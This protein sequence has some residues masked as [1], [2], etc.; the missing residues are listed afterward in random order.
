MG[1][2]LQSWRECNKAPGWQQYAE[3]LMLGKGL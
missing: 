3:R 2:P 1:Q